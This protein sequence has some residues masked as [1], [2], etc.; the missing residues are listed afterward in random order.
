MK[1]NPA[2]DIALRIVL[3][4]GV[5]LACGLLFG[6]DDKD[7]IDIQHYCTMVHSGGWPDFNHSYA[8]QCTA[9]GAVNWSGVYGR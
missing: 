7:S 4:L 8:Q 3:G 5:A 1:Y 9:N 2:A 6:A